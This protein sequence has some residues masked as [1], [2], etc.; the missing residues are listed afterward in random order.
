MS[1]V[2]A[3]AASMLGQFISS[4]SLGDGNNG[5]EV[6]NLALFIVVRYKP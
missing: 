1:L 6:T 3:A 5:S 2:A 4:Y